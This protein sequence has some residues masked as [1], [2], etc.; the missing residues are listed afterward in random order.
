V[1]VGS[2]GA[3]RRGGVQNARGS[4]AACAQQRPSW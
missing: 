3:A 4:G 2:S 1:G